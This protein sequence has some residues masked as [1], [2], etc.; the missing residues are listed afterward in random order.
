MLLMTEA[1]DTVVLRLFAEDHST[2]QAWIEETEARAANCNDSASPT[3]WQ[4]PSNSGQL[5][6]AG[7]QQLADYES[8]LHGLCSAVRQNGFALYTWNDVPH[9]STAAVSG[10]LKNLSLGKSDDGVIRDSSEL[11]LLE[12][13]SGTPKGRFPPYQSKA[14]NW[15]TDGY[16]NAL[17]NSVRCFT[18]HC[19]E[20]AH[21]GGELC[22]M[23][24]TFLVLALLK[25]DP[26]MVALLSHP[27]AMTLPANRDDV[28][29]NRPDRSVPMIHRKF[30]GSI[31]LRFTTRTQNIEWR[32]SDTMA[33]SQRAI[34]LIDDNPDWQVRVRLARDE[35]I[36]TRNVLHA[37][38]QFVDT[39]G[40]PKRQMLRGRFHTL[41]VAATRL[42][43]T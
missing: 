11:S 5:N 6:V 19:I 15:H 3:L 36:I 43:A 12:D 2:M 8:T 33:A 10:L 1:I 9:A 7:A 39:P 27:Q 18:L 32:N 17:N 21:L 4:L 35:G 41:P 24:D 42:T 31:T 37:R 14:L 13:L 38:D 30:D 29:H 22:L 28:G 34:E 26:A 25:D 20:P 23:D 40:Q 16:Y